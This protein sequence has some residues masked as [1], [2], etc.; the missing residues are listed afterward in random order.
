MLPFFFTLSL[1]EERLHDTWCIKDGLEVTW[2][3]AGLI[4]QIG[5]SA[6]SLFPI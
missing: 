5:I 6:N 1:G 3:G 2:H 4:R